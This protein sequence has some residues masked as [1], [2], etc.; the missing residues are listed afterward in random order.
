MNIYSYEMGIFDKNMNFV[1]NT[2]GYAKMLSAIRTIKADN[3]ACYINIWDENGHEA[4]RNNEIAMVYL[5][6]WGEFNLESWAPNTK[7][8]WRATR[9]PF[10]IYA[11]DGTPALAISK[12]SKHKE[13]AWELVKTIVEGDQ[14]NFSKLIN[15]KSA[16]LAVR[17][18]KSYTLR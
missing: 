13:L 12:N 4:I 11:V 7:G 6:S 2:P 3:L 1:R 18:L 14:K 15:N 10:G 8:K 9:L 16:F 5:G 17:N